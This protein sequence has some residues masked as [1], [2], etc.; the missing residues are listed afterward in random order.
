MM[1]CASDDFELS[2]SILLVCLSDANM[3]IK[4]IP[5]HY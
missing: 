4:L 2:A 5:M 1:R 3:T